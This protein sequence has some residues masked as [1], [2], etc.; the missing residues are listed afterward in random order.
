[1]S[2]IIDL[3]TLGDGG[4]APPSAPQGFSNFNWMSL[5][6]MGA[7]KHMDA[8]LLSQYEDS[9]VLAGAANLVQEV[10]SSDATYYVD[11]SASGI[12]YT[13]PEGQTVPVKG[14][15]TI[16][17]MIQIEGGY[18]GAGSNYSGQTSTL[19]AAVGQMQS[20]LSNRVQIGQQYVTQETNLATSTDPQASNQA[21][22]EMSA[23]NN[24]MSQWGQL[25][26]SLSG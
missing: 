14:Y 26:G 9:E 17:Q 22:Q 23:L 5:A 18:A 8:T 12:T 13:N 19:Q 6:W 24:A 16:A 25:I 20:Q 21:G 15:F 11:L 10:G 2:S 7:L 3:H 1:M 4:G